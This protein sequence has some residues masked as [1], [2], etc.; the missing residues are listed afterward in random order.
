MVFVEWLHD[1]WLMNERQRGAKGQNG[2][3]DVW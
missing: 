3:R 1:R 2:E